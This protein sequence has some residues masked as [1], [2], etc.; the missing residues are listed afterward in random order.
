MEKGMG[1]DLGRVSGIPGRTHR[2]KMGRL[3]VKEGKRE[4]YLGG[5]TSN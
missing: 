1:I 5:G 3:C 4:L 2:G